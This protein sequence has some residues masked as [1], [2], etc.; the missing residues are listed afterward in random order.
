MNEQYA[1]FLIYLDKLY[2]LHE[3]I[4]NGKGDNEVADNLR[5]KM[6]LVKLHPELYKCAEMVSVALYKM[7]EEKENP[8][9][10]TI[11]ISMRDIFLDK[12]AREDIDALVTSMIDA[13]IINDLKKMSEEK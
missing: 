2:Q 12:E 8:V 4:E 9:E 13:E 5:D 10:N 7:S 3:E 11:K 1:N 6:D